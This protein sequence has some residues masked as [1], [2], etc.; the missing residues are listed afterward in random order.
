METIYLLSAVYLLMQAQIW[1]GAAGA[2]APHSKFEEAPY[3]P[4]AR[5]KAAMLS[6]RYALSDNP[7]R[8]MWLRGTTMEASQR[9]S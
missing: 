9:P 5:I 8:A 1:R 6:R 7:N 4:D 2:A 3:S